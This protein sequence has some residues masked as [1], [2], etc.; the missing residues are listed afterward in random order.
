MQRSPRYKASIPTD[1][2]GWR[3]TA[4]TK[5]LAAD[6]LNAALREGSLVLFD[7]ETIAE[8]RTYVRDDGNKMSGSPFDDRTMS[9]MIAWQM[10]KHVFLQQYQPKREPGPGTMGYFEKQLYGE[11]P[12]FESRT[13]R[14]PEVQPIG[15]NLSRRPTR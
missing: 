15:A 3:T 9:M 11:L 7:K 8:L 6:E 4:I 13:H 1:I 14:P 2:L 12:S 10:V 5:P